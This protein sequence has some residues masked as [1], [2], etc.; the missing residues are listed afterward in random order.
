[1]PHCSACLGFALRGLPPPGWRGR[2]GLS[3]R[4]RKRNPS[5]PTN[6]STK[7][8]T[9]QFSWARSVTFCASPG[10]VLQL[11]LRLHSEEF[12]R[13]P[14][15]AGSLASPTQGSGREAAG[16]GS[17]NCRLQ[18][19]RP[20]RNGSGTPALATGSAEEAARILESARAQT[21]T[22]VRGAKLE[23]KSYAAQKSSLSRRN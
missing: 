2:R 3:R 9:L 6:C 18:G 10:G 15:G 11:A 4:R 22:A 5:R 21:D 13:G 1:M 7:L 19:F 16:A 17:G 8:S 23:L 14:K 20:A 12:G